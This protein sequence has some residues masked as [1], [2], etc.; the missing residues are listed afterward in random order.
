MNWKLVSVPY[1]LLSK[2]SARLNFPNRISSRRSGSEGKSES[3]D[4]A[5]LI[6]LPPRGMTWCHMS[7]AMYGALLRRPVHLLSRGYSR[8]LSAQP[9]H[10]AQKQSRKDYPDFETRRQLVLLHSPASLVHA[11]NLR[12]RT[13]GHL[14]TL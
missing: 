2:R 1:V 4:R 3:G 14:L 12:C 7:R 6:L 13:G 10:T 9:R 8:I 11:A 5:L